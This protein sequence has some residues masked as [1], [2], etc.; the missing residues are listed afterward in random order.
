SQQRRLE[1]RE[2]RALSLQ[3]RAARSPSPGGR[4][5]P[6]LLPIRGAAHAVR[7]GAGTEEGSPPPAPT[8][9]SP[10][11]SRFDQWKEEPDSPELAPL[12]AKK[13][14]HCSVCAHPGSAQDHECRG[15][16]CCSS[17]RGCDPHADERLCP[18]EWH[19]EQQRRAVESA[20]KR[21][22][23]PA[24]AAAGLVGPGGRQE[25]GL[26]LGA[27]LWSL[28][29]LARRRP[30]D[31][32]QRGSRALPS[33]GGG[34]CGASQ[35]PPRAGRQPVEGEALAGSPRKPGRPVSVP[36]PPGGGPRPGSLNLREQL[37]GLR[38]R[39]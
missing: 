14:A 36:E 8:H 17:E 22:D 31:R 2:P 9:C 19:R 15:C 29:A 6:G 21:W 34:S 18:C 13:P 20:V 28:P 25:A 35:A 30:P 23:V 11:L 38:G 32:P 12:S 37:G 16:P 26:V 24:G 33:G 5:L 7:D 4:F 39:P 1:E 10:A 3:P 27:A